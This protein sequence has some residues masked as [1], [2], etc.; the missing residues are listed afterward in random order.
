MLFI[1]LIIYALI[2]WGNGLWTGGLAFSELGG[3]ASFW[4]FDKLGTNITLQSL[5]AFALVVLQGFFL[6]WMTNYYKISREPNYIV[7]LSYIL[8]MSSSKQFIQLSPMLL[9]NTFVLL[10][11][12]EILKSA[13][14]KDV[15]GYWFNAGF[16]F[17]LG[18]FFYF[19]IVVYLVLALIALILLRGLNI[20]DLV[21]LLSGVFVVYFLTG[22]Y[23]FWF[24]S[25]GLFI[26][27]QVHNQF[28]FLNFTGKLTLT[29]IVQGVVFGFIALWGIANYSTIHSKTILSVKQFQRLFYWALLVSILSLFNQNILVFNHLMILIVPLS[30][31]LGLSLFELKNKFLAELIHV[32][33]FL[34]V[35]ATQYQHVFF[36]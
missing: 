2:L 20:N 33:L 30:V 17:A 9:A 18:G 29:E 8:L 11:I 5:I 24:D 14:Q 35:I 12:W 27:K 4:F 3:F 19:S 10:G 36:K 26:Q 34:A 15:L 32:V 7:G 13:K 22:V 31:L 21:G 6:N 16:W 28:I 23:W 25:F 1:L